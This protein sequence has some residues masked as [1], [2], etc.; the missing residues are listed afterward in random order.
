MGFYDLHSEA[1]AFFTGGE[2]S[3][4]GTVLGK[5]IVSLCQKL[6]INL[7]KCVSIGTDGAALIVS[8]EKGAV[9]YI[10]DNAS[11]IASHSYCLSHLLNLCVSN[12]T[13]IGSA[14]YVIEIINKTCSFFQ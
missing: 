10:K 4:T 8:K 3:V 6:N 12:C 11:K 9:K 5:V 14:E 2:P 1:Q 13:S 7:K